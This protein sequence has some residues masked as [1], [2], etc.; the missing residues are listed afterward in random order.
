M[1]NSLNNRLK[2]DYST[3][4][5]LIVKDTAYYPQSY[6][7]SKEE[8]QLKIN[9]S[10][11]PGSYE[12]QEFVTT[13][14]P[15]RQAT[16]KFW[17]FSKGQIGYY[18][19]G[20]SGIY[21]T[22]L[23][24]QYSG[25]FSIANTVKIDDVSAQWSKLYP[26]GVKPETLNLPRKASRLK[27]FLDGKDVVSNRLAMISLLTD[28]Y[29]KNKKVSYQGNEVSLSFPKFSFGN[30]AGY[31]YKS[32]FSKKDIILPYWNISMEDAEKT[33][34][35]LSDSAKEDLNNLKQSWDSESFVFLDAA[36]KNG[37]LNSFVSYTES[38]GMYKTYTTEYYKDS[39][40]DMSIPMSTKAM[41]LTNEINK[42]D[43]FADIKPIYNFYS[44][45]YEEGTSQETVET[46][47]SSIDVS[48]FTEREMPN[49]Y[50]VPLDKD[51][52]PGILTDDPQSKYNF[53]YYGHRLLNCGF[54]PS[55]D[56]GFDKHNIIIDQTNKQYLEKY[57]NIKTQFPF[58]VNL[59]FK[60]DSRIAFTEIFNES[61]ITQRLIK[62]WISNI[63][64]PQSGV[65]L[66]P[67]VSKSAPLTSDFQGYYSVSD[68]DP[69]YSDLA[70]LQNAA[71]ICTTQYGRIYSIENYKNFYKVVPPAETE[72]KKNL[73]NDLVKE[74]DSELYRE[75]DLNSWLD[76]YIKF[77][78]TLSA[79]DNTEETTAFEQEVIRPQE[80]DPITKTFSQPQFLSKYSTEKN[81]LLDI[82]KAVKFMG[83][84]RE[85][86]NQT[87]RSYEQILNG[88][89]AYDET[90]FYRIQKVAVDDNG[91]PRA[92]GP[93]KQNIWVPKP[94]NLETSDEVLKYIDTQVKY[95]Q[96]YEYTI[97]AYRIVIGSKYGFQFENV[98]SNMDAYGENFKEYFSDVLQDAA[99]ENYP[100]KK[101]FI[102]S[103]DS[104]AADP[105]RNVF[106]GQ[107]DNSSAASQ[108]TVSRMAMF[109]VVCEPDVK[110]LEVPFY[111]KV[112][113][114]S[115]SPALAPQIDMLPLKGEKNKI[116]INFMP[117][118]S[119]QEQ[120][121]IY[122]QPTD[123]LK[124]HKKRISQDR[125]LLKAYEGGTGLA[126]L[127]GLPPQ[128]YVE[129]KLLFKSDDNL[130]EYEVYRM[131]EKPTSYG[132]FANTKR[133]TVDA[134]KFSSYIDKVSHNKKYYYTFRAIDVHGNPT[135]PSP[136]YQLEMVENS[137]VV[138]PVISIFEFEPMELGLKTK[139]F[140][141]YL[142]IDAEALQGLVNIEK[143]GLKDADSATE[144]TN[145]ELG[146]RENGIFTN[147]GTRK[148][149]FRIRSKH[150]GKIIDLNVAFRKRAIKLKEE[151]IKCDGTVIAPSS[152]KVAEVKGVE[153]NVANVSKKLN[154]GMDGT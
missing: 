43:L 25:E 98:T 20:L 127:L 105:K 107:E 97:Y 11:P 70:A 2:N 126:F 18:D 132:S 150:T 9:S 14:D 117:T 138:Y 119:G 113:A 65:A 59:N 3:K 52:T 33:V 19:S 60:R 130:V 41:G 111:K 4:Y 116:K 8:L 64:N 87:A 83:K 36:I 140:K 31:N 123:R 114:V 61:G 44:K 89:L 91:I 27:M 149:K 129:P 154:V 38:L 88:D 1:S 16:G 66:E 93:V 101:E 143:S 40:I 137:G 94:T 7:I 153:T 102:Y 53:E 80:A 125:D 69:E 136:V 73:G 10:A 71:P 72:D 49:I 82:I 48:P 96:N 152:D 128:F 17:S 134:R 78:S 6:E 84:Y 21:G 51:G 57:E 22:K 23:P 54:N 68:P 133:T 135:N 122:M 26:V 35:A 145:I 121:P 37:K 146:I 62:T 148:Y 15:F 28:M 141:R 90:L 100:K 50:E 5:V 47:V 85:L 139:S 56:D 104:N 95:E 120:E 147:D 75:F 76:N 79:F 131:E 124:F 45:L 142:K 92:V 24:L 29:T 13:V 110:L 144:A 99:K 67:N 46:V 12:D 108:G 112:V 106:F 39:S 109:D 63:F 103:P 74:S 81:G 118:A 151:V 34:H 42:S 32:T 86:V 77:L 55:R 58:Y 30:F 115:D